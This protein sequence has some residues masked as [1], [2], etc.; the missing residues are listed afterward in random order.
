MG[1]P[2]PE[3][4]VARDLAPRHLRSKAWA[5]GEPQLQLDIGDLLGDD[6]IRGAGEVEPFELGL[7]GKHRILR[8]RVTGLDLLDREPSRGGILEPLALERQHPDF[9]TVDR[10]VDWVR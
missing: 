3:P 8:H 1:R 2:R 9:A 4:V 6:V 7:L 5:L 10:I